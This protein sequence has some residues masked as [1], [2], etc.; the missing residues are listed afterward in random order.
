MWGKLDPNG[1]HFV[2]IEIMARKVHTNLRY[3]HEGVD[4]SATASDEQNPISYLSSAQF[5]VHLLHRATKPMSENLILKRIRE[6]NI[7]FPFKTVHE[8]LINMYALGI[9]T[10]AEKRGYVMRQGGYILAEDMKKLIE[11]QKPQ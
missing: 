8:M 7:V 3:A 6:N 4:L 2:G 10:R 11:T 1:K 5:V 9:V